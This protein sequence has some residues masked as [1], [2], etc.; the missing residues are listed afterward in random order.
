MLKNKIILY[1]FL[2]SFSTS[3]IRSGFF[4]N[5]SN[6]SSSITTSR[7]NIPTYIILIGPDMHSSTTSR[8]LEQ[9]E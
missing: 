4:E 7:P 1:Y 2:K 8:P 9:A 6:P 5:K 3:S